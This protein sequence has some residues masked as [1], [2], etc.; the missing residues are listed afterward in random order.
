MHRPATN[1]AVVAVWAARV[2]WLLVAASGVPALTEAL[3]GRG[4]AAIVAVSVAAWSVFGVT[5]AAA[6]V[7]STVSLTVVRSTAPLAVVA[8]AAASASG[9]GAVRGTIFLAAGVLAVVVVA[10]GDVGEAFAQASAYGDEQR[11]PLRPPAALLVP[12]V[13]S[14]IVW[15]AAATSG[16]LLLGARRWAI[17]G[18]L[19][20]AAA[21]AVWPLGQRY[22]RLSKRWLVVVP[23][24]LVVHDHVVLAET[25][26]VQGATLRRVGL[27]LTGTEAA[28]LT[29]PAAGHAVDV[30][31][32]DAVKVTFAATRTVPDGRAIHAL[33]FLVAPTRPGRA[34]SAAAARGLA[35]AP[36]V[37]PASQTA[38]APPST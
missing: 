23:A 32:A 18:V 5:L 37:Q 24:G 14:W 22:H 28:D 1:P 38:S 8:A 34:L 12:V 15:A 17:G 6:V 25:L 19:A 20:L 4:T 7:P 11:F 21:T 16:V 13:A 9:S 33:S 30:T 29:G 31:V 2:V 36:G 27:A 10:G 35:V 3:H 26:L